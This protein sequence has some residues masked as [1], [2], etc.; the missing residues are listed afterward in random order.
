MTKHTALLAFAAL[1]L[2]TLA[3]SLSTGA[4]TPTVPPDEATVTVGAIV[5]R[6]NPTRTPVGERAELPEGAQAT[7]VQV[8]N[9]DVQTER[10]TDP[11]RQARVAANLSNPDCPLPDGWATYTVIAGDNLFEIAR[12]NDSDVETMQ[13]ANCLVDPRYLEVGQVIAVPGDG[14]AASTAADDDAGDLPPTVESGRI[15][16]APSTVDIYVVLDDPDGRI[17]GIEAGCGNML[18][19]LPRTVYG[20]E[21]PDERVKAALDALFGIDEDT[22]DE[23]GNPIAGSVLRVQRL[24]IDTGVAQVALTGE[25]DVT[26]VCDIPLVR[27]Q[28][29]QT[30]LDDAAVN[31]A[32]ITINGEP[33]DEVFSQR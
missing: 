19:P 6:N 7:A 12:D 30:V 27:G 16:A 5:N 22:V 20:A 24:E 31:R 2:A 17:G 29:E 8:L 3:C 1:S 9:E 21:A 15:L 26:D 28:I 33:L 4:P 10:I 25:I 32:V 13:E 14:T 11:T 23:Y 18:V